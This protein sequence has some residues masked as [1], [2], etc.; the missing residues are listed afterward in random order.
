MHLSCESDPERDRS[1]HHYGLRHYIVV[2]EPRHMGQR[3]R[4]ISTVHAIFNPIL[5]H[6]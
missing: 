3:S 6:H 2:S 5:Q 1:V 4:H